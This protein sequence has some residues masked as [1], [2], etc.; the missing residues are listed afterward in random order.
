M[1][2][3]LRAWTWYWRKRYGANATVTRKSA[4]QVRVDWTELDGNGVAQP[5][6]SDG[7]VLVVLYSM[8]P[9]T[10]EVARNHRIRNRN[11]GGR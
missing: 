6:Y 5:C 11:S 7:H 3:L 1:T 4:T 2:M 9:L 10:R 8:I